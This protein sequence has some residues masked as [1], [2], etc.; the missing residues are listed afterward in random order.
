[1]A[2]A[3]GS[4]AARSISAAPAWSNPP[5]S[6]GWRPT[7]A[8]TSSCSAAASSA[9]PIEAPSVPTVASFRT[10]ASRAWP[11]SSATGDSQASR[12]QWVSTTTRAGSGRVGRGW[13]HLGEELAE[14]AHRGAPRPGAESRPFDRAVLATQ[15]GEQ[16]LGCGGHERVHEDR[17]HAEPL[18]QSVERALE[19]VGLRLVLRELPRRLVLHVS[20]EAT[21]APPDLLQREAPLPAVE[22]L[23]HGLRQAIEVGGEV[24]GHL[25]LRHHAVAVAGDHAQ[26]PAGE[27]AVL[28]GEL[29]VV[30]SLE[31][32][33]RDRPV[34][35]E[36][37]LAQEVVAEGVGPVQ[38]HD[39]EGVD[40]VAERL[41]HLVLIQQ[42]VAVDEHVPGYLEVGGH[43]QRG[44]D[45][46]VELEDVLGDQVDVS[47][48][49]LFG[50]VL[51]LARVTERG[52]VVEQ[53]VDPDVDDLRLVPRHRHAP[54]DPGAAEREVLEALP[55]ERERLVVALLGA[56]PFRPLGVQPLELLLEGRQ[57][58][59]PVVLLL[60][61]ELD[62][63]DGALV[64]VDEL[65]LG[66]EVGAAR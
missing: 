28:V 12:W 32:V 4:P 65:G 26:R 31:P 2:T 16:L 41:R 51:A 6:C 14:F 54:A 59:E 23:A 60:L 5:A 50:E 13:L 66:L 49:E 34:L 18:G 1:M 11:T 30:T 64:A 40:H 7:I 22:P 24:R 39:L 35:P 27:V 43:E 20:V 33:G 9:R 44:P 17:H 42:Q 37:D 61:L 45:D 58:E 56:D 36:A 47:G 38:V 46:R 29:G 10:P 53:R 8:Y 62:Q 3:R 48:P 57:P 63:V 15:R 55:D 19:P 25:R 52:V 21:H